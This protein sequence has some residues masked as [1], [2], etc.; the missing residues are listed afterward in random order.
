MLKTKSNSSVDKKDI[1]Q[2]KKQIIDTCKYINDKL[3]KRRA[4]IAVKQLVVLETQL[5]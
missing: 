3:Y 4:K 2:L 5:F 1:P